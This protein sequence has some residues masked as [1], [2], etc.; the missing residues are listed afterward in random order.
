MRRSELTQRDVDSI[1]RSI[2]LLNKIG[3]RWSKM[4]L[5]P[6]RGQWMRLE[7]ARQGLTHLLEG[8]Q[9]YGRDHRYNIF[10]GERE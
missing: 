6:R 8:H 5:G 4:E 2:R 9:D 3:D 1:A 7:K 10:T